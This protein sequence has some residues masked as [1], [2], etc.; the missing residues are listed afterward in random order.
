MLMEE[1]TEDARL[2]IGA[3]GA[4]RGRRHVGS[5][6]GRVA[7]KDRVAHIFDCSLISK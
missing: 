1:S 3:M 2:G 6:Y 7:H 4:E 5:A